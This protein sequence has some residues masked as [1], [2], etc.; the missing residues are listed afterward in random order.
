MVNGDEEFCIPIGYK[1][2]HKPKGH[3]WCCHS[4][5]RPLMVV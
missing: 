2:V 3:V 5:Q 1:A 4:N